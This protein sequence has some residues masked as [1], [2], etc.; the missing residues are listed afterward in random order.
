VEGTVKISQNA[1]S[2]TISAAEV[3]G[4]FGKSRKLKLSDAQYDEIAARLTKL[5]WPCDLPDPPNS[6]GLPKEIRTDPNRWWDFQGSSDAAK[7]LLDSAPAMLRHWDGLRWATETSGGYE[8]IKTL[9]NALAIALPYIEWP[10]GD[11]EGQTGRKR[12]KAWHIPS[13]LIAHVILKVMVEAGRNE[14]GITRNSVVVR[15]VHKALTRMGYPNLR[16][17]TTTAIGAH[18]TRWNKKFGLTPAGVAELT[19]K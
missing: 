16:M 19:T 6:P 18:L 12:P 3:K 7:V 1:V 4:W 2:R 15:V 10:F 8:A 11:Y 17:I 13:V 5:R 14:P 9:G